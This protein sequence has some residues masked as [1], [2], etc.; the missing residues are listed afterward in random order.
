MKTFLLA[1]T[2]AGSAFAAP[3]APQEFDFTD[4]AGTVESVQEIP[5]QHRFPDVFEHAINPDTVDQ[6]TV[7]LDDGRAIILQP[8]DTQRFAPGE[9]VRV[10]HHTGG[11][12]LEHD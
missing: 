2:F 6:L 10:I 3:Y 11:V 12:Q 8:E 4:L 7:R 5:I 1:A 9:R